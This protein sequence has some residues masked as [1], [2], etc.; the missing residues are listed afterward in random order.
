MSER[1]RA[2]DRALDVLLCFSHEE[3]A[4]SLTTI[5]EQVGIPKSTVHRLMT[6]LESSR[7]V[8]RD[9]ATGMYSLGVRFIEMAS[10]V[11]QHMD[12]QRW[13]QPYLRRLSDE[14]GETVDLAVLDGTHVV[15]LQVIESPHRVKLAA[16]VGQRLPAFCTASG[17]AFLAYLPAGQVHQ[18]L[19]Q[20]L[21][22]YT[23]HTLVSL[24]DLYQDL[25][26]TRERGFAISEQEYEN[27]VHAIAAPIIDGRGSPVAVIAIAGPSFR[28][29][30]ERMLVLGRSIQ[31]TIDAITREIGPI[32]L[33]TIVS[34]TA[35]APLAGQ[36]EVRGA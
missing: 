12:L 8:S 27:E 2:V 23:S 13:V 6:T 9:K 29:P 15:Y 34:R 17:K 5:A 31:A 3:P 14:C 36:I 21:P 22:R 20:G 11:L 16:A 32:A 30:R 4:L 26:T 1:V 18:I 25:R 24:P 7:F 28:L 35:P 10:V 19:D 33:S